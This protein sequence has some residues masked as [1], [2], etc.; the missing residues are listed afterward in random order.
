MNGT[1][2]AMGRHLKI[3]GITLSCLIVFT[4]EILCAIELVKQLRLF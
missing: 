4:L 1:R 3:G 2:Q